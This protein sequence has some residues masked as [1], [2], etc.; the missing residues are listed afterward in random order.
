ML[1]RHDIQRLCGVNQDYR[2]IGGGVRTHDA[3]GK[4]DPIMQPDQNLLSLFYHVIRR[5]DV[6]VSAH[7]DSRPHAAD[8]PL[9][10]RRCGGGG[11]PFRRDVDSSLKGTFVDA[12]TFD[13]RCRNGF[14]WLSL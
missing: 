9:S 8:H 4:L 14:I 10:N 11:F 12:Q 3:C 2:Q 5:D 13:E 1:F 7:D 6:A